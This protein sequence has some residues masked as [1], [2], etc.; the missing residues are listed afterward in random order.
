MA[1][2]RRRLLACLLNRMHTQ[3]SLFVHGEHLRQQQ[4]HAAMRR[5]WRQEALRAA[6]RQR[7]SAERSQCAGSQTGSFR[8]DERRRRALARRMKA[9][10]RRWQSFWRDAMCAVA[11]CWNVDAPPFVPRCRHQQQ[12]LGEGFR[13]NVHAPVFVP[14]GDRDAVTH[15]PADHPG[16]IIGNPVDDFLNEGW[17][18]C[19]T[20]SDERGAGHTAAIL[21]SAGCSSFSASHLRPTRLRWA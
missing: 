10:A 13:W 5:A 4:Q 9:Q 20:V 11:W 12:R 2:R 6:R 17:G 1:R 15:A 19:Q 8:G 16:A 7:Q 3:I 14:G 21:V 18:G